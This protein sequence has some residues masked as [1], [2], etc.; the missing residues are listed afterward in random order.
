M[1]FSSLSELAK[2]MVSPLPS[3]PVPA[4]A[5]FPPLPATAQNAEANDGSSSA[6]A[7][8]YDCRLLRVRQAFWHQ[9]HKVTVESVQ[10]VQS[11]CLNRLYCTQSSTMRMGP[12]KATRVF[13]ILM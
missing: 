6:V 5:S 8:Y 4:A 13:I 2:C 3:M 12:G 9:K 11:G 10:S 7:G 1:P